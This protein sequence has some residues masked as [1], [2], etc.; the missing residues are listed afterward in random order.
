MVRETANVLRHI[1]RKRV[2]K[3]VRRQKI[4]K[5]FT[6][7]QAKQAKLLLQSG[8]HSEDVDFMTWEAWRAHWPGTLGDAAVIALRQEH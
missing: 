1:F 7:R 6:S 2:V 3:T 8:R 5:E 4:A